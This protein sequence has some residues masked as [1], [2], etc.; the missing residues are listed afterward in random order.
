MMTTPIVDSGSIL[1]QGGSTWNDTECQIL[2]GKY[3]IYYLMQDGG[4]LCAKCAKEH[5]HLSGDEY[6]PQ[7]NVVGCGVNDYDETMTCN[8]CYDK[9]ALNREEVR[10]NRG[11]VV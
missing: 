1:K 8:H 6:D 10:M 11:P 9:I 3:Q 5:K 4:V 2:P 7:W